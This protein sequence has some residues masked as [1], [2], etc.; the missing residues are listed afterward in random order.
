MGT[1]LGA[2]HWLKPRLLSPQR[3]RLIHQKLRAQTKATGLQPSQPLLGIQP[4]GSHL[5]ADRFDQELFALLTDPALVAA[6]KEVSG[7]NAVRPFQFD[8]LTKAPG[9][10]GTPW[11]RDRDFLPIDRQSYTCWIPLDPIPAHCTLVYAE[12]TAQLPPEQSDIAH[13][14][15]LQQLLDRH[16]APM[17]GLP[18]MQPGDVDIHEGQVW[19]YGPANAT[20]HWRRALGVVFVA[21]GTRL[22]TNPPGFSGAAGATMRAKTLS[23]LFGPDAEGQTVQGARHPRL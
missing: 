13:P 16:G 10:P 22:C 21:D 1:T 20:P 17:Q 11:H 15:D 23:T 5:Q 18:A 8:L 12:G 19:H 3:L 14:D 6:V 4:D 2:G 9:G 7:L